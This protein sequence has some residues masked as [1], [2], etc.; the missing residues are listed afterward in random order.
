MWLSIKKRIQKYS[1]FST[2]HWSPHFLF[3]TS[4]LY[5]VDWDRVSR[6]ISLQGPIHLHD[7]VP[8]RLV[9]MKICKGIGSEAMGAMR[10]G[11]AE[12][13]LATPPL[14]APASHLWEVGLAGMLS[15]PL[16]NIV[17]VYGALII[18]VCAHSGYFVSRNWQIALLAF[19]ALKQNASK[20]A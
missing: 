18:R 10:G 4:Q 15:H 2:N 14:A 11:V 7:I 1:S 8:T 20:N 12:A 19:S 6:A 9:R 13:C 5:C 3:L 17:Q 16:Y